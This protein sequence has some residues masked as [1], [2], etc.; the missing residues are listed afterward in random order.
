[1]APKFAD[2]RTEQ[3]ALGKRVPAFSGFEAQAHRR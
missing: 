2:K 1:M 3:F